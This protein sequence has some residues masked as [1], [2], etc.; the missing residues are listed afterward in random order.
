MNIRRITTFAFVLAI[1]LLIV[2]LSACD[3]F[4]SILSNGETPQMEGLS[5][6]IPIGVVHPITGRL[7]PI[8]LPVEYS[9]KLAVKEINNSQLGGAKIKLIIED[10]RSTVEG[11]VEA[12]NKLIHQDRVPAILGPATSSQAQAAFPIAQQNQI[13]AFSPTSAASG[14]SAIGDFIFR[15]GLTT[16][17]LIPNGVKATQEKLGYQ[18]VATMYDENDLFSTDSDEVVREALAANGVKVLITE[19]FPRW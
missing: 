15:A 7:G 5:G 13:V 8:A 1:V 4:I 11:A 18:R 17:V 3:E 9:F 2:G 12:F 19:T 14:L 10:G 6:E 16:G